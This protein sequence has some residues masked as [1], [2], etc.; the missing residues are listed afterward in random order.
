MHNLYSV[1]RLWQAGGAKHQIILI[2]KIEGVCDHLSRNS[3]GPI[4]SETFVASSQFHRS[5][6]RKP[7]LSALNLSRS[8]LPSNAMD[9]TGGSAH[10]CFSATRETVKPLDKLVFTKNARSGIFGKWKEIVY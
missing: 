10:P 8:L 6:V 3:T 9:H 1:G 7:R 4:V 2:R 5:H